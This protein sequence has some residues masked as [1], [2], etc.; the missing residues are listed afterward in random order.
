[1][2]LPSYDELLQLNDQEWRQFMAIFSM[3]H[4]HRSSLKMNSFNFGDKVTFVAR[5]VRYRGTVMKFNRKTVAVRTTSGM[6]WRVSPG[7]LQADKA[8]EKVPA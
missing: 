2:R 1:M 7:L 3:V 4:K 8:S 5:G 6:T